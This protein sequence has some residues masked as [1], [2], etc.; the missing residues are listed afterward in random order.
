MAYNPTTTVKKALTE[1]ITVS[2]ATAVVVQLLLE[3]LFGVE[4]QTEK[5]IEL[6]GAIGIIAGAVRGAVNWV[7]NRKR[8]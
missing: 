6:S 4:I 5:I 2:V 7:K 1:G 8:F 3:E